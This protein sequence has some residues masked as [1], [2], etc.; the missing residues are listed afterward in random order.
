MGVVTQ[1]AIADR[2]WGRTFALIALRRFSGD[3]VVDADGKQYAV[4]W[5]DGAVVAAT[6]PLPAD[7][8]VRVAL[9][10]HLVNPSQVGDVLAAQAAAPGHDEIEV[11]A[12]AVSLPAEQTE[13]LRRRVV[14]VRAM[15][16]FALTAGDL[17]LDDAAALARPAGIAIDARAITYAGVKAYFTDAR[18]L[19]ELAGLGLAFQLRADAVAG[20]GQYGF[21]ELE[22]PALARLRT[23]PISP[24][25]LE[26]AFGDID[27][28]VVRAM[29]YA[30]AVFGAVDAS[31]P[32]R[33][34]APTA[35]PRNRPT[36]SP[37]RPR[38]ETPPRGQ[39]PSAPRGRPAPPPRGQA[40]AGPRAQAPTAVPPR[41]QAPTM[42]PPPDTAPAAPG[43]APAGA[44]HPVRPRSRPR[45]SRTAG[46][47]GATIRAVIAERLAALDGGADHFALLGIGRDAPADQIRT[48]YFALARQL[49]PDRLAAVGI[50]DEK[51][52]AQRLFAQ[53]NQAFDI[54]SNPRRRTEYLE[55]LSAGG[56]SAV[57][58]QADRAEALAQRLLSA[59]DHFRRGEMALRRDQLDEAHAE[60]K[61]AVELNPDEGE[62]HALLA[63]TTYCTA[64][65]KAAVRAAIKAGFDTAI[66]AS[67]RSASPHLYLGRMARMEGH[68]QEAIRHF[69]RALQLMPGHSEAASELRVLEARVSARA[70]APEKDGKKGLFGLFKKS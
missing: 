47:T 17:I 63:W 46:A 35:P 4:G 58:A 40:P 42:P 60:F 43:P 29:L 56:E 18:L 55:V 66:K 30:L 38:P 20:L 19:E 51:R 7:A 15:R 70:S 27:S 54:L 14:A 57:R 1:G 53:I 24:D 31:S 52:D 16:T 44:A 6:S 41:G 12:S 36:T 34:G 8:V 69:Q 10:S 23:Q 45:P 37:P 3:L 33:A 13:R 2:P 21:G 50:V 28:K 39:V 64:P 62:H 67:P 68:D 59:E 5:R 22:R 25:G 65:D 48:A 26:Q 61:Q 32:V 9:T 11:L 49:H